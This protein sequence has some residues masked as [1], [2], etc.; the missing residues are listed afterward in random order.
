MASIERLN[1][2]IY[3]NNKK[4]DFQRIPILIACSWSADKMQV[5]TAE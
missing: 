1:N 4:K 5:K 3:F 2:E